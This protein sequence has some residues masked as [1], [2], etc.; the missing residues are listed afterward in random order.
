MLVERPLLLSV[1][2]TLS[3]KCLSRR[4]MDWKLSV[5]DH[6]LE[7]VNGREGVKMNSVVE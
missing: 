6:N 7:R 4:V 5:D 3:G 2:M 1:Q